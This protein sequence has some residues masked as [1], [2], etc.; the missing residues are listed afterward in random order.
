MTG[1]F[2]SDIL[3]QAIAWHVRLRD[4]DDDAW[5]CFTE[6]LESNPVHDDAYNWV[7]DHDASLDEAI[8][9]AAFPDQPSAE[10]RILEARDHGPTDHSQ[11]DLSAP[12]TLSRRW[13]WGAIA[14]SLA[15]VALFSAQLFT[16]PDSYTLQTRPGETRTIALADGSEIALNGGTSII[17]DRNDPRTAELVEGEA[18]FT[19][20]HDEANPFVVDV[21][22]RRLVDIGTAFNV[23]RSGD[24]LELEVSEGAVRFEG[25]S[26]TIELEGGEGLSVD[27]ENNIA[28]FEKSI[29]AIGSWTDGM[30]V[31]ENATLA[32]IGGDIAR[33][34]GLELEFSPTL[35]DRRFS[36]VI[37]TH[38]G[39]EEIRKR[40][41]QLLD[42][43][44]SPNGDRWTIEP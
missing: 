27:E 38:G 31:Y 18:H 32:E 29:D 33:A 5:L 8:S 12:A 3:D 42:L 2:A 20:V 36:G 39:H 30:L 41:E 37:Q 23:T 34:T 11:D 26:R 44:V 24:Q 22:G 14:A 16:G 13:V 6:W 17:L 9:H 7:V 21:A 10:D 4:G 28:V 35:R 40:L 25:T 19:V 1:P 43:T 15:L